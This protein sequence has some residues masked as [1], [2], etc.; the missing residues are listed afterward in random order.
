MAKK[1]PRPQSPRNK[2][3]AA[4]NKAREKPSKPMRS[5][6]MNPEPEVGSQEK[7]FIYRGPESFPEMFELQRAEKMA[8]APKE[9]DHFYLCW[10][11]RE[12]IQSFLKK[13]SGEVS[14]MYIDMLRTATPVPVATSKKLRAAEQGGK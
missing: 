8:S 11:A 5:G 4:L 3:R 12:M 14:G 2:A 13:M 9:P 1:R 10:E 6:D 7:P